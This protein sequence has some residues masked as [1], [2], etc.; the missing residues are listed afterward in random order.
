MFQSFEV[1]DGTPGDIDRSERLWVLGIAASVVIALGMFDYTVMVVGLLR[2]ALINVV[3]FAI[4]IGLMAF[5]SRRRSNVAR[6]LL[7]PFALLILFYDLARFS[8]MLDRGWIAY[9]TVGRVGL[10]VAAIYF[11][12]TPRSRAWFAGTP[13]PDDGPDEDWS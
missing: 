8:E 3:L 1:Q 4:S 6:W 13:L 11:L 12:F 7:I 9:F 5:A 2:A 10:M